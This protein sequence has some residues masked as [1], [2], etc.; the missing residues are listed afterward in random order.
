MISYSDKT[1]IK[2]FR[3]EGPWCMQLALKLFRGEKLSDLP[4]VVIYSCIHCSFI[5]QAAFVI[6]A[7][8]NIISL[9]RLPAL[10]MFLIGIAHIK[11]GYLSTFKRYRILRILL[12][13]I[14][15]HLKM[16]WNYFPHCTIKFS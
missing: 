5:Q 14:T 12:A 13:L 7:L 4:N 1:H 9:N 10:H 15:L 8:F 11:L 6:Y 2:I 3:N 16:H